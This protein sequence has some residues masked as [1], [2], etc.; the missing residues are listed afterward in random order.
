MQVFGSQGY[1]FIFL[2]VLL[3]VLGAPVIALPFLVIAGGLAATGKL[4]FGFIVLVAT[5][6]AAIGDVLW[7]ALGRSGGPRARKFLS[8]LSFQSKPYLD[9]CISLVKNY[10]LTFLLIS[11]FIPGIASLA[12]P[13]AGMANIPLL[14]FLVLDTAG[15]ILWVASVSWIGYLWR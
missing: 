12:P 6:A 14:K 8:R 4:S 3:D 11:K 13:A 9:R 10:S 2:T 1:L 15:R 7:Y 5:L